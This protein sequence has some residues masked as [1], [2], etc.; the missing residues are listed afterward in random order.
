MEAVFVVASTSIEGANL[1]TAEQDPQALSLAER[2]A[3]HIHC[4]RR[5]P[6]LPVVVGYTIFISNGPSPSFPRYI[7]LAPPTK[8]AIEYAIWWD[9]DITHLYELEHIWVYV[10]EEG[11]VVH[12]EGS[13]HGRYH[14][15]VANG[16]V[17]LEGDHVV[18]YAEPGKHAFHPTPELPPELRRFIRRRCWEEA[19]EDGLLVTSLFEGEIAKTP[20]ADRLASAYLRRRAFEPSFAFNRSFAVERA[21]LLPWPSLREWIP[22]R[23]GWWLEQLRASNL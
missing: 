4:D 15:L 22:K 7:E 1:P 23:I 19:G 10:G 8:L 18:V 9:W 11:E 14:P 20:E 6:F 3:P 16:R 21:A 13:W 17:P 2:Y 12:A 5:E